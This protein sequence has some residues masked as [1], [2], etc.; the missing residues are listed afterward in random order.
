MLLDNMRCHLK[1]EN[2]DPLCDGG[3]EHTEALCTAIDTLLHYYLIMYLHDKKN[4]NDDKYEEDDNNDA[5]NNSKI[6]FDGMIRTKATLVSAPL[7]ESRGFV[8]I[9]S[10]QNDMTTH[11]SSYES[12]FQSYV[13]RSISKHYA[14]SPTARQRSI[15][16][17]SFLGQINHSY[18]SN[19]NN[20]QALS[21]LDTAT[22]DP[23]KN[24]DTTKSNNSNDPDEEGYDPWAIMKKIN[25]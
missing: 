24:D 19:N 7:L 13:D 10:L 8:P 9:T 14:M 17:V 5:S 4:N 6:S 18:D 15:D 21:S 20:G 2:M 3:S 16:I 1:K 25:L 11:Y 22:N 12:C 23:I